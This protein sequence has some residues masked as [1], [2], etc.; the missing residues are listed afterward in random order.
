MSKNNTPS[1][2]WDED[3]GIATCVLQD[4]DNNYFIGMAQC[5]DADKD[6]QSEKTGCNLA[7]RR[8]E[9]KYY[10]H[11]R[12]NEIK[13]VLKTLQ[14]L[15]SNMSTSKHFNPKGYEAKMLYRKIQQFKND[16]DMINEILADAK[17]ELKTTIEKKEQF[18][19][20]VRANRPN[21]SPKD[22]QN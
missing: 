1:F 2:T 21:A 12:D 11:I 18:Y 3:K 22:G 4:G 14:H 15:Y 19:Q 20:R 7:L 13:P 6:M 8:A 5:C 17:Q 10:I 9:I 16:L